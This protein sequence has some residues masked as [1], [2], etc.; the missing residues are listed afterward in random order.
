MFFTFT[1]SDESIEVNGSGSAELD[2]D[3]ISEIEI[4]FDNGDEAIL[5]AI[6][7]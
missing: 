7:E 5:K 1:G 3:S 2:D 6:R 4:S